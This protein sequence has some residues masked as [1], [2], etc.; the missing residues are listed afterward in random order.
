MSGNPD[1]LYPALDLVQW[2]AEQ[3][4]EAGLDERRHAIDEM[5]VIHRLREEIAPLEKA[6]KQ[7]DPSASN[8]ASMN[9][10]RRWLLEHDEPLYDEETGLEA[11]LVPGG[12]EIKY[13]LPS[14]IR[15][16][17]AALYRRLEELG[18]FALDS[19]RVAEALKAGQ[20]AAIEIEPFRRVSERTARLVITKRED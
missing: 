1:P 8:V 10:L 13:D 19:K 3:D 16:R 2:A 6:L 20:L 9:H 12:S 15:G 7:F 14:A 18:L 5:L 17:D 11:R 4:S